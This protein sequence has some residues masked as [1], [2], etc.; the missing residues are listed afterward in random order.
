MSERIRI[1]KYL[2]EAGV[3][4]RREADRLLEAGSV[5]V[6]GRRA[7]VG[8]TVC[9]GQK[10]MVKGKLVEKSQERILLALYKPRGVVCTTDRRWKDKTVDD[11]LNYHRR[12]FPVGRLDKESEGLLLMTND[13][14]LQNQ[15]ARAR[16]GHEKEYLV[17]V[18]QPVTEDFLK[19]MS[20]GVYLPELDRT[21]RPCLVRKTGVCEFSII[22]TQGM[23]RQIRRMCRVFR[24]EV[25]RL[26]RIRVMNILLGDLKEG[27]YR[28]VTGEERSDLMKMLRNP[29]EISSEFGKGEIRWNSRSK[30]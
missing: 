6:D 21:T 24:Y 13:G 11:I 23:N 2:S 4:S 1:N 28:E 12:L 17:T 7:E 22:L 25:K 8:E 10:I 5:T 29:K 16:Y 27:E 19:K 14:D 26:V 9:P 18:D 15:I 30:E 3:C 20:R